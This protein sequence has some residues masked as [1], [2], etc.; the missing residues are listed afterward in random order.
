MRVGHIG[1]RYLYLALAEA[2][3]C[4]SYIFV[5]CIE[6]IM[7]LHFRAC[8]R[9][10]RV[11]AKNIVVIIVVLVRRNFK[12]IEVAGLEHGITEGIGLGVRIIE[13]HG[14]FVASHIG[15]I[16]LQH[17]E[18]ALF[19]EVYLLVG[20]LCFAA[21]DAVVDCVVADG[22]GQ[23]VFVGY[24][25]RR[26][27]YQLEGAREVERLAHLALLEERGVAFGRCLY[28]L[29]LHGIEFGDVFARLLVGANDD[30]VALIVHGVAVS[31]VEVGELLVARAH[32]V[33]QLVFHNPRGVVALELKH[34]A[35]AVAE[36]VGREG[37]AEG[38]AAFGHAA[39]H[40][41]HEFHLGL[42]PEAHLIDG[43]LEVVVFVTLLIE[44]VTVVHKGVP[45]LHDLHGV[46][47]ARH[48]KLK[49]ALFVGGNG[50]AVALQFASVDEEAGMAH[51]NARTFIEHRTAQH[52]IRGEVEVVVVLLK[53]LTVE[54]DADAAVGRELLPRGRLWR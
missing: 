22:V 19:V 27:V 6:T 26:G 34:E 13:R 32:L 31:R 29:V 53:V 54:S 41:T 7:H 15:G 28:H 3:Q 5:L 1:D 12:G 2:V 46:Y 37:A 44:Q 11:F 8:Q 35:Q 24:V 14:G 42:V 36:V 20:D 45:V 33:V 17:T 30:A 49:L 38:F 9:T 23:G 4:Y 16:V 47:A 43:T 50:L 40:A 51:G 10:G 48:V 39:H 52:I 25:G 21:I 18:I